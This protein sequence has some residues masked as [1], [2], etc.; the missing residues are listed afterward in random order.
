MV[1]YIRSIVL[2]LVALLLAVQTAA[3]QTRVPK[4]GSG[5][6]EGFVSTQGGTI[7]LGGA[8]VV[9]HDAANQEV[10]MILSDGDGHYRVTALIDGKYTLTATLEG[11]AMAK[12]TAVVTADG[13]TEVGLDLPI[14]NV[15]Q[16]VEV[17]APM[18]IVS[19]AET[20]STA[21]TIT[22]RETDQLS[23]G[24]GLG[25]ALR[26]LASVI[27][28]PGG[29]SI[30]GGRPTQA[31]VQMGASTLT[32]PV[33]GLVHLTLPDDAIDSVAVMP[34]PYAVEYGRFSSGLVVIQ[35]RRAGDAWRMR[36]NNLS[37]I[38]RS[39]RHQDLF[40]I[41]GITGF[42]PN[43]EVGGPI[44]KDRL[45]LEQTAQYRYSTDEVPSRPEDERRITHWLSVF[46]RVDANLSLRH[47][48]VITGGF[49][50][51]VTT[52]ASLGTFTPPDA[53]VDVRE[54]VNHGTVTERALWT[55]RLVSETT[56][57][58]RDY[59]AKV[60]P[61]GREPMQLFPETTLGN[62]FNTQT[63]TPSTVQV[64]Q[65]LSGSAAG[66]RGLH[67]FKI[68]VD[69]LSNEY[70]GSS[71]SRPLLVMRP[72]ATLARRLDFS[73]PTNEFLRT[74]D[75]A[76]FAQDRLQ[77]NT[78]W[79]LEYGARLDRDGIVGRWNVTP[80]VGAALLLNQAGSSVLRGGYGL[81]YER[82]PSAAGAFGEF[83]TFTDARYAADGTTPLGPTVP[84]E[85][86]TAPGLKTAR[87]VTWDIGYEYRWKP[88]F[89]I[90]ASVLD[91]R[92]SHE[93]V[94]DTLRSGGIGELLL[95]STGR[96]KYRDVEVGFHFSHTTRADLTASYARALAEG[97]LNTFAN[98]FDTM[99]W[100]VVA[101]NA[102]GP[103][104]TDVPHRFFAR[105]RLLP[106]PTW[107][108]VGIADWRT[109]LPYSIVDEYLDYVG[110]RNQARMPNYFR[111]DLGLEHR[112]HIFKLQPWI[113]V[114][115]Y[116]AL[117]G[118]LPADV[119]ANVASPAFGSLY[120]SQF[121]QFRL[122]VRF[123]R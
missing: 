106:S 99:L 22:S 23:A 110:P 55:D 91:R 115:A 51:S 26:L 41:N 79:Y 95:S 112:F 85:R 17:V 119:Q 35:T 60:E 5:V 90:H 50:P 58:I 6:I 65:T 73:G 53:T 118:F 57:Q 45:F 18:S 83:E 25:G 108:I 103:L 33:L 31:G 10:A 101:P 87:S 75:V 11:F 122:Q 3:A 120:N 64:I 105:G 4:A 39:K 100:P 88:S 93:L 76:F 2:S 116:N 107:L 117:N 34:N 49:F 14:A 96:S 40:N 92:G 21:D 94:L 52:F 89:S 48:L 28:V 66:P 36:L 74:T 24:N 19:A 44:V 72:D 121:R 16:T 13:T 97:D 77:P 47:S 38:F 113:G 20:L 109:G 123:E 37:P 114:R 71:D 80:R 27:E 104:A 69:I 78:R 8:Q 67:L 62:F 68:G 42:A 54:R 30:K 7:R 102:Y 98:F 86:V 1:R 82:T 84:F 70:N 63:R 46:S 29:V 43:F 59:R 9:V 81:F 15:T 56:F 12:A 61:Q 111:L 32:D